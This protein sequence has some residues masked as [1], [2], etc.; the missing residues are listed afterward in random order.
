MKQIKRCAERRWQKNQS[1]DNERLYKE[2]K[3]DYY[4]NIRR[5]RSGY[6]SEKLQDAGSDQKKIHC[7]INVLSGKNEDKVYPKL[8]PKSQLPE[9]FSSYSIDN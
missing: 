8:I 6:Y 7:I 9:K 5:V 2:A 1:A 3:D 4:E